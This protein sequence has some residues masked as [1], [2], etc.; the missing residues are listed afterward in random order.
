M[1]EHTALFCSLN[2]CSM[3]CGGW[4]G[5]FMLKQRK[6]NLNKGAC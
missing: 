5:G 3:D 4:G 2:D 6:V 1:T